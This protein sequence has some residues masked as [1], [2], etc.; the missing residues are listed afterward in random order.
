MDGDTEALTHVTRPMRRTARARSVDRGPPRPAAHYGT[1]SR[2]KTD[3]ST[4]C[5]HGIVMDSHSRAGGRLSVSRR[6]RMH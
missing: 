2:D 3:S 1:G 5:T 4:G 6:T